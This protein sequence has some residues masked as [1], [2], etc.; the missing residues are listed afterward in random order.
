MSKSNTGGGVVRK[1]IKSKKDTKNIRDREK[2]GGECYDLLLD[3]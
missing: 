2:E 1:N 3:R